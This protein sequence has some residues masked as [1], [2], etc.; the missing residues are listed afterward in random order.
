M[1][2]TRW[3]AGPV[4]LGT[5]LGGAP[6]RALG[7][8]LKLTLRP[9]ARPG[10]RIPVEQLAAFLARNVMIGETEK[11]LA[12]P[13]GRRGAATG[14]Q[15][16]ALRMEMVSR[17]GVVATVESQNV[18]VEPG[19]TYAASTWITRTSALN[20]E[21]VAPLKPAEFVIFR[22]GQWTATKPRMMPRGCGDAAHAVLVSVVSRVASAGS[23]GALVLCL[24]GGR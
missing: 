6:Q 5:L 9:E 1:H 13:P 21:L 8:D 7:Q 15:P 10:T 16:V 3:I 20:D 12:N 2:V 17:S 23:G 18:R 11:N 24:D 14:T 22:I 4:L 19:R